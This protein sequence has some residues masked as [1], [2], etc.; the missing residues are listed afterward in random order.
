MAAVHET[1]VQPGLVVH[2]DT[3][4]L[5][6][7]GGS[8][9]NAK[10][11]QVDRAVVGPHYFLILEVTNGIALAAPLYSTD[12]KDRIRLAA[13]HKVGFADQWKNAPS[14]FFKW[15]FWE[16]PVDALCAA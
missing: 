13:G 15:Q 9:T 6:A 12:D 14:Y 11:D 1:E 4:H 5:R 16:I 2:L 8:S 7:S 3:Q 10:V